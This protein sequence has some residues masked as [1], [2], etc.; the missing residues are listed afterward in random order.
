MKGAINNYKK[1]KR[2][3]GW[4][5]NA[6]GQECL[7]AQPLKTPLNLNILFRKVQRL[8]EVQESQAALIAFK[9]HK[10]CHTQTT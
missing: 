8:Y 2:K 10:R 5:K 1:E 4:R 9:W 7:K 6:H 3:T